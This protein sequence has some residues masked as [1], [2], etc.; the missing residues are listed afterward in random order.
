MFFG[1]GSDVHLCVFVY[2]C[3]FRFEEGPREKRKVPLLILP[4]LRSMLF[5]GLCRQTLSGPKENDIPR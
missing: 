1:F 3:T 2:T 4:L 5:S